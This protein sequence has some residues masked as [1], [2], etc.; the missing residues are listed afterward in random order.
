[1]PLEGNTLMHLKLSCF[2]LS[3]PDKRGSSWSHFY[4]DPRLSGD[5][6]KRDGTTVLFFSLSFWII[7]LM[8]GGLLSFP[9]HAGVRIENPW[10]RAST[11]PNA[12]LFMTLVN[13]SDIP[14][15]LV[16]AQIDACAS[17]ELHTHVEDNGVFR[18]RAVEF[19]DI[20]AKGTQALAPGGYHVMLM[21]IHGPLQEGADVP[22]TLS[23]EQGDDVTF[24][25][26]VK[27]G[28]G[29]CCHQD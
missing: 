15:K 25:A 16:G 11:G 19:I 27:Q 12:A 6:K 26:P 24:T 23:F 21:K 1:M 18:M 13:T 3:S 9:A 4:L 29:K 14:E 10:I 20:P 2:R 8:G 22:V 5:D 28:E 17:A 7:A